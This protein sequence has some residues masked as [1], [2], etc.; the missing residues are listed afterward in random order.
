MEMLRGTEIAEAKLADWR[1]MAQ[2]LHA[3][4]LAVLPRCV[5]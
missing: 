5:G 2:G 1:K 3:R 4:H